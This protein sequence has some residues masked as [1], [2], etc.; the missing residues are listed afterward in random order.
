MNS[1]KSSMLVEDTTDTPPPPP[2]EKGPRDKRPVGAI[3][4]ALVLAVVAAF[5]GVKVRQLSDANADLQGQ[6][7]GTKAEMATA[8]ADLDKARAQASNLQLQITKD[9]SQLSDLRSQAGQEKSRMADLQSQLDKANARSAESQSQLS[10]ARTQSGALQA[11][12]YQT[13]DDSTRL[14]TELENAQSQNANL[15]SRLDKAE[16]DLAKMAP[17]AA[18]AQPVPVTTTFKKAF[19][20]SE[21][22][23][24]VK[25]LNPSPLA[26]SITI[27]GKD[28]RTQP[29]TIDAGGTLNVEKLTA[30]DTVVIASFGFASV[31]ATVR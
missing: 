20:S 24:Q 23:M 15:Q 5:L 12:L 30:G 31:N 10:Q 13:T 27:T 25:N 8:Q 7:N 19:L 11:R 1:N 2:L 6:Q 28:D 17:A 3:A 9:E 4:I 26:V 16:G 14:R 22:T 21:I 18:T 29:A